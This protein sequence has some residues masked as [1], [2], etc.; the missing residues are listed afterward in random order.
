MNAFLLHQ[1]IRA[2]AEIS[3]SRS[4]GPGGQNV[5][6]VNTKVT[7]RLRLADID[8]LSEA[9]LDRARE[10]LANRITNGDEIVINADEE[11]SQKTNLERGYF[12][13]EA[14]IA[15]AARLP[16]HRR[17]TKPSR[18]AR[19]Q[20]LQTKHLNSRKKALRRIKPDE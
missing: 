7:L 10:L 13:L 6:K 16:K 15:A 19:E 9:E 8:G 2:A 12:R 3:F 11:R 18:A 20:R 17:P 14:L 4:G 1:S 5:N